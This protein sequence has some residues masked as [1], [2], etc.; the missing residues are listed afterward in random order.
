MVYCSLTDFQKAVY[1]TVLETEDV[2]LILQ[3]SEPCTCSSGRKRR[4][5]CYK[6]SISVWYVFLVVQMIENPP[7]M[8]ETWVHSLCW[9]DP[10]E[11]SMAMPLVFLLENPHGQRSLMG[12]NPRG[13]RVGHNWVTKHI[14]WYLYCLVFDYKV[15]NS[16]IRVS[17][18]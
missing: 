13:C 2:S 6:V 18:R 15:L 17:S 11:E 4:N 12:Y 7:A 8:Q 5:C 16:S 14:T 10:L 9:E 3:S 1:Q